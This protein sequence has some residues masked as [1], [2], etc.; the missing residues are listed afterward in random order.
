[1]EPLDERTD[2]S[3]EDKVNEIDQEAAQ[4]PSP[5]LQ[6]L[7]EEVRF[8]QE[9]SITAYNRMHNRHNRSR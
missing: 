2:V 4:L 1:M 3:Y 9:L 7:I 5:V 8:E 6:R